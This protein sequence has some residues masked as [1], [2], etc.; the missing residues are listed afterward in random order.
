MPEEAVFT[1]TL[2]PE[3][4]AAFMAAAAADRPASRVVREMMRDVVES[5]Q[6]EPGY[7]E[8]L[9][10]KVEKCRADMRA[11]RSFSQEQAE[12]EAPAW[13]AKTLGSIDN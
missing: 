4:R 8:W 3:L 6:P 13:R 7:D 5:Q 9:R 1:M 2:D 10:A 11:G 12:A